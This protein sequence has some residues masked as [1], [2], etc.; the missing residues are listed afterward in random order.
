MYL[1]SRYWTVVDL[2]LLALA[3]GCKPKGGIKGE[4]RRIIRLGF[5]RLLIELLGTLTF[6][7]A[8]FSTDAGISVH[9]SKELIPDFEVEARVVR[10]IR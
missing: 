7:S 1:T 3:V 6:A 9:R 8:T 2:N 5:H 4:E 10:K